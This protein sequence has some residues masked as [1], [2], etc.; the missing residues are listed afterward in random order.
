[1]RPGKKALVSGLPN[2]NG[3]DANAEQRLDGGTDVFSPEK[4]SEVMSRVRSKDTKPERSVRSLL[5]RMGYRFRIHR[6]DLPGRPDIVLPR[7]RAVVFVHGCFWHQHPGCRKATIPKHNH[8][9]WEAKL[10]G[11]V[12]RDRE[13]TDVLEVAGWRVIVVWECEAKGDLGSLSERLDSLLGRKLMQTE[14]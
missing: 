13:T 10:M 7:Y 9:F 6:K 4:R 3:S 8:E 5:H 14:F 2:E 12:E 11:N 1:M